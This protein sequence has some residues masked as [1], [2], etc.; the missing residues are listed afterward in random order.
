MKIYFSK[1]TDFSDL[2]GVELLTEERQIQF[3]RFKWHADKAQCLVAGL[4]LRYALGDSVKSIKIGKNGK[5]YVEGGEVF[6]NLSHSKDVVVLV[7]D[8]KEVGI[9]VEQIRPVN[10]RVAERCY[11]KEELDLLYSKSDICEFYKLWTAKESIIKAIGSGFSV[12][13]SSF[14][15]LPA[16]N[17]LHNLF[18]EDW[19]L[20]WYD[21]GE[22]SCCVCSKSGKRCI[23]IYLD[24][25][26]LLKI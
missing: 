4:L 25:N 24:K 14:S 1:T 8:D 26:D 15:V 17:G 23:P 9:D 18:N 6:F 10:K 5:P 11:T 16:E 2:N 3:N 13:P 12:S 21:F 19:H 22:Y 7:V 20:N